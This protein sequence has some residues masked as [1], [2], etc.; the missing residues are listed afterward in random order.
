MS[1][2][3]V[4][5]AAFQDTVAAS[6]AK[7]YL[8]SQGIPASLFDETT[9][10]TDWLLAGA[11]GGVKLQVAPI[12]VE[13]AEMLLSRNENDSDDEEPEETPAAPQTAI[14][15]Q[16]IAEDLK[17]DH[18]DKQPI[19]KL[20]DR[21]FR[22]AVLGFL[23]WPLQL[24]TLWLL[25]QLMNEQGTVSADRRWKVWVCVILAPIIVVMSFF[26][27]TSCAFPGRFLMP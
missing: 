17:S 2:R 23:F 14:A 22:V 8:E 27:F 9:V 7:N 16:E 25:F 19:N 1:D 5:V 21:L 3:L 24:Y 10:A 15:A 18:E 20:V 26:L 12:H 11:I 13:R 6:L 4:T